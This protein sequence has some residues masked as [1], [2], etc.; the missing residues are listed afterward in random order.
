MPKLSAAAEADKKI[1]C[2]AARARRV[3]FAQVNANPTKWEALCV[4]SP[5]GEAPEPREYSKN[6]RVPAKP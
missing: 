4:I 5:F 2:T 3:T 6:W 1:P